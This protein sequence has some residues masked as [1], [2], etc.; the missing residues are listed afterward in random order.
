MRHRTGDAHRALIREPDLPH[1]QRAHSSDRLRTAVS[2]EVRAA[3][4]M[5]GQERCRPHPWVG[6]LSD[7]RRRA[8]DPSLHE[9]RPSTPTQSNPSGPTEKPRPRPLLSG[10][11]ACIWAAGAFP[12]WTISRRTARKATGCRSLTERESWP[13]MPR[14]VPL[15]TERNPRRPLEVGRLSSSL[16]QRRSHVMPNRDAQ[17]PRGVGWAQRSETSRFTGRTTSGSDGTRTRDLRRDR[18]AL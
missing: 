16:S 10:F 14:W 2:C 15:R 3:D 8:S 7:E 12:S 4:A 18:P 13:A 1:G 17:W 11:L 6:W 9:Q 5:D